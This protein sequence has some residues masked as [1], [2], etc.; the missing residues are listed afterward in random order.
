MATTIF[1]I[2]EGEFALALVNTA[3]LGYLT[4]WNAPANKTAV[5]ALLTDYDS[6]ADNWFQQVTSAQLVAT[7]NDNDVTTPATFSQASIVTP[8]PGVTSFDLQCDFLQ[9]INVSIGL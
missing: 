4:T 9:D 8:Q 7:A 3:A 6:D 1:Q 5:T 2:E